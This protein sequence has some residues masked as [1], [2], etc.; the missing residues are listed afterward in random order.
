MIRK[1]EH[2]LKIEA[3]K[4]GKKEYF[5]L[6]M[7]ST[8]TSCLQRVNAEYKGK[9]KRYHPPYI[10]DDALCDREGFIMVTKVY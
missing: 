2:R 6:E 4:T 1:A 3:L 5:P 8:I 9:K 7:K 10:L